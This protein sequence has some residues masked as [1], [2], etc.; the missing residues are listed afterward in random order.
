MF[1]Q[2][3]SARRSLRTRAKYEHSRKSLYLYIDIWVMRQFMW[4]SYFLVLICIYS[5]LAPCSVTGLS[6]MFCCLYCPTMTRTWIN[7]VVHC[8]CHFTFLRNTCWNWSWTKQD[9]VHRFQLSI[10]S[11]R[12]LDHRAIFSWRFG[13]NIK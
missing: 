12:F 7:A 8:E 10:P 6:N 5:T 1:M 2:L 3:W 4:H 11:R 13:K 9:E